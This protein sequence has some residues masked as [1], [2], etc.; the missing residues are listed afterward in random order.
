MVDE[1]RNW[2]ETKF[3]VICMILNV[4][5]GWMSGLELKGVF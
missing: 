3:G 2:V 5:R 4:G 1:N